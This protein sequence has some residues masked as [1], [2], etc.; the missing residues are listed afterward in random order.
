MWLWELNVE[1]KLNTNNS[2]LTISET[3]GMSFSNQLRRLAASIWNTQLSHLFVVALV[4]TL[5]MTRQAWID[6]LG[7]GRSTGGAG[8]SYSSSLNRQAV[9]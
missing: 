6:P 7:A 5:A 3:V 2:E 8:A 4:K 9:W 1:S